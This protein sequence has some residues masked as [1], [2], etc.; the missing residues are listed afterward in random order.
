MA[1]YGFN[2]DR[3]RKKPK[4]KAV[5]IIGFL[6]FAILLGACSTLLLWRSLD[7]DFKNFTKNAETSAP[8]TETEPVT[9]GET[10]SG[11]Y[12]FSAA[13]T[14]DDGKTV[15]SISL[16][17]V[18]LEKR[19]VRVVPVDTAA[20]YGSETFAD[21]FV[22]G[23]GAALKSALSGVYGIEVN[24]FVTL[25]EKQ[26]RSVFRALGDLPLT[27]ADDIT[28]DSDDMYLELYKGENILTC[29]KVFKY[30]MYTVSEF[31]SAEAARKNAEIAVA[32]FDTFYNADSFRDA[33]S[34]FA[35]LINC[36]TSDITI[37]D[38]TNAKPAIGSLVPRNA[39]EHLRVYVSDNVREAPYEE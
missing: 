7:Y 24:R 29:D 15:Y 2:L 27:V 14:S 23:G 8:E 6:C 34:L 22:S 35:K 28:Y 36:C 37:V 4:K 11:E 1:H 32:A 21:V 30:M 10:F 17:C 38:F 39:K 19:T 33:D 13:V 26:Y 5:F 16:I 25:N 20:H 9:E 3:N 31:D 12:A 18:D